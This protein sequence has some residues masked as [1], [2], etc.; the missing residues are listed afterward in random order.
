M[1]HAGPSRHDSP[2]HRTTPN[3]PRRGFTL[4][5]TLVVIT[6]VGIIAA[7]SIPRIAN[8]ANQSRVQ[9][10]AQAMQMEVQQAFAIAGRNRAPV[11]L[12]WIAGSMQLQ[13]TNLAGT[14]VYRRAT[15]GTGAYGLASSEVVVTPVTLTVFPNGLASDSLVMTVTRRGY[16]R[17]VRVARSGMVRS[18]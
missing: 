7:L 6:I 14:V 8:L 17:R 9:R 2:L 3:P 13:V 10:A 16:S 15:L 18:R 1:T 4:T 12:R 11:R 5:E